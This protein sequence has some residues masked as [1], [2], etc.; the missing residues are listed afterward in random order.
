MASLDLGVNDTLD[1]LPDGQRVLYR[2]GNH[3]YYRV[4]TEG[5]NDRL[6]SVTTLTG[7]VTG[8]DVDG[9]M[10][11]AADLAAEGKDWREERN[12][13]AGTGTTVHNALE[14]LAQGAV[15]DLEDFAEDERNLVIAVSSWW[16]DSQ[17]DVLKTEFVVAHP[18]FDYAGRADLLCKLDGETWLIDLKTSKSIGTPKRPKVAYH[19]QLGLYRLAMDACGIG[20]PDRMGILHVTRDG[21]WRL[22]ET[23]VQD[24]HVVS[25]P[26][27]VRCLRDLE[28]AQREMEK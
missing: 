18:E 17:P 10:Q 25:I 14:A 7:K 24:S 19:A 5:S 21:D 23:A 12:K 1:E 3:S 16:L 11:W 6:I 9:L 26:L 2:D 13:S 27:T 8:G 15:P 4:N 28:K 22:L 20:R